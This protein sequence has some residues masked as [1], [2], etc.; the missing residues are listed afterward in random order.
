[1][2]DVRLVSW[3]LCNFATCLAPAAAEMNTSTR[4]ALLSLVLS[5]LAC[6]SLAFSAHRGLAAHDVPRGRLATTQRSIVAD[7]H[8]KI[9]R[10][11]ISSTS[12]SSEIF[13]SLEPNDGDD[14]DV[15]NFDA[16]GFGNYLA[17]YA[18]A[19]LASMGV[20]FAFVKFVLLDY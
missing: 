15:D 16:N 13:Q 4:L 6:R 8:L 20:T 1:M 9:A 14:T 11:T 19:L 5:D 3:L 2:Y 18:L 7:R 12:R 10:S 17:P